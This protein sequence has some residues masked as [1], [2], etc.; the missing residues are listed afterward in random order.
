[1]SDVKY[2]GQIASTVNLRKNA[3]IKALVSAL[4]DD[5]RGAKQSEQWFIWNGRDHMRAEDFRVFADVLK[6]TRELIESQMKKS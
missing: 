1:M 5:E 4:H 2:P 6:K 3:S